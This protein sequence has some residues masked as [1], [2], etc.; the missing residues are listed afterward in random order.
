ME[1]T[2]TQQV[3]IVDFV[4]RRGDVRTVTTQQVAWDAAAG[5]WV[6]TPRESYLQ[7]FVLEPE[8]MLLCEARH[9]GR[10]A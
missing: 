2:T 7:T 3:Y 10:V 8:R 1:A 4:T 9:A 6:I 5:V